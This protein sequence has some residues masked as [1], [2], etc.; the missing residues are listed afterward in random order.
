[1]IILLS[2]GV[3]YARSHMAVPGFPPVELY[4]RSENHLRKN[5]RLSDDGTGPELERIGGRAAKV[6]AAA[7]RATRRPLSIL[8]TGHL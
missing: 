4:N 7:R 8:N 3:Q 2:F 6:D 1:M 5:A